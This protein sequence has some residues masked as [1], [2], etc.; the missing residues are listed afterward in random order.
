MANLA[1]APSCPAPTRVLSANLV[2]GTNSPLAD[3][4]SAYTI[5][6]FEGE[7]VRVIEITNATTKSSSSTDEMNSFSTILDGVRPS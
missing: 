3:R 5:F 2:V 6:D 4:V 1:N 7:R